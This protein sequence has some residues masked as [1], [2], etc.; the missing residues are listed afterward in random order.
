MAYLSQSPPRREKDPSE[1]L[2]FGREFGSGPN[3]LVPPGDKITS[4]TVVADPGLTVTSVTHT[5]TA[6]IGW[7]SGG[8]P[9]TE[10]AVA[11]RGV[12]EQGR[13]VERS[14]TIVVQNL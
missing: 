8:T 14:L 7:L 4:A 2:D 3:P 10:Y 6:V 9:G 12:T 1:T 11:F 13:T 5:D